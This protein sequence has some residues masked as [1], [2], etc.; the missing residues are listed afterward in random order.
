M[1]QLE[2]ITNEPVEMEL[3]GK[4][5]KLR[6]YK[7]GDLAGLRQKLKADN[8]KLIQYSIEDKE[9]QYRLLKDAFKEEISDESLMAM[10]D[11]EFDAYVD[12]LVGELES[13]EDEEEDDSEPEEDDEEEEETKEE[14]PEAEAEE[15]EEPEPDEEEQDL[16]SVAEQIAALRAEI[17]AIRFVQSEPQEEP[18]DDEQQ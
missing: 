18:A 15:T 9:M 2:Q 16:D 10:S 17:E 3:A 8:I 14:L 13:D 12:K 4:K 5:Y 7:V 11:E 6:P 1:A